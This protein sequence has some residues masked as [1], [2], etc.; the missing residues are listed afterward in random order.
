MC[1]QVALH[2][3]IQARSLLDKSQRSFRS[4]QAAAPFLILLSL[5][6]RD[7]SHPL[8]ATVG[9]LEYSSAFPLADLFRLSPSS[10]VS[11][12]LHAL[13]VAR[14]L[15]VHT[16]SNAASDVDATVEA[17]RVVA[18]AMSD[19]ASQV[20][21]ASS[22]VVNSSRSVNTSSQ[23]VNTSSRSV[24]ASTQK[25]SPPLQRFS[26]SHTAYTT[27]RSPYPSSYS[28]NPYPSTQSPT[29]STQSP[30]ISTHSP[31]LS[32]HSPTM[33][34]PCG[35]TLTHTLKA[36]VHP[37]TLDWQ[38]LPLCAKCMSHCDTIESAV[39]DTVVAVASPPLAHA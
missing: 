20:V 28:T 12:T 8:A 1:Q 36:V 25:S 17:M 16:L 29:I 37:D 19:E 33:C 18:A 2:S 14:V 6:S 34:R 35:P 39:R 7:L 13:P 27:T 32:T 4:L 10:A 31:T 11:G 5:K 15:F 9:F 22:R 38:N 24:T 21:N 30:T 3:F 23:L 26:P